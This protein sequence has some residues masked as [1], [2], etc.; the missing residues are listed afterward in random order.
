MYSKKL[1][2]KYIDQ[3]LHLMHSNYNQL[4]GALGISQSN[5]SRALDDDP[6]H[7]LTLPQFAI[8]VKTLELNPNQVYHI[9][10]GKQAKEAAVKSVQDAAAHLVE[11]LLKKK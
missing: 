6:T 10:T 7:N 8:L 2:R 11:Q 9:L 5:L 4:A 3:Q 1:L